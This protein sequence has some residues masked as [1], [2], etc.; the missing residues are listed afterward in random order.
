MGRRK[1]ALVWPLHMG[2]FLAVAVLVSTS[3]WAGA[4]PA[5][6][7]PRTVV[8]GARPVFGVTVDSVGGLA[9]IVAAERAL[10]DR[11]TTRVYMSI[12]EPASYY[13]AAVSKLDGVGTVM[14]ELLDSSDA[15]HIGVA[16]FQRR[17]E[18]YLSVLGD[19]VGIWEVGNEVNGDW[20]GPYSAGA[21]K[22]Q[23]AYEDVAAVGGRTALTLYANEYGPDH[24][25]DGSGEPTPAE[26]SEEHVSPAVRDGLTYV[27]ESY[28]PTQCYD[29]LPTDAQ[30]ASEME[31]LREVYPHAL[32]GFG[33]VGLPHPAN[34]HDV[35]TAER[36][37]SWAYG[38][39]PRVRGYVGGYFWW[40]A[41][42]DAFFG[43]APLRV[44]LD[45]AFDSE[46]AVLGGPTTATAAPRGS[47][48]SA[49]ER[50]R[51]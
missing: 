32:L 31:Q 33:E 23:E 28:Y 10:P 37:M 22:L 7:H 17:V 42:E 36:V 43:K 8:S 30:V 18:S 20:T 46:H 9:A 6:A 39:D 49:R 34:A 29:V 40:Y 4:R 45:A 48:R 1:R 47:R 12:E 21:A 5:E 14:G 16:A 38:L 35:A 26:Y 24:C 11:P 50:S 2:S 15:R 51:Y 19:S 13:A 25:G 44:A 27:F 3:V 41:R